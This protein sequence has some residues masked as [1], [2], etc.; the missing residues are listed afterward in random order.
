MSEPPDEDRS[1]HLHELLAPLT[2]VVGRLQLTRRHLTHRDGARVEQALESL[3][4][5]EHHAHHTARVVRHRAARR[6]GGEPEASE[7]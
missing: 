7:R 3:R 1:D 5:A 2:V 4:V 6:R